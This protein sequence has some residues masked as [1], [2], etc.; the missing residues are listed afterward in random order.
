MT[1]PAIFDHR[2]IPLHTRMSV[3]GTGLR[4][5]GFSPRLVGQPTSLRQIR[6][7]WCFLSGFCHVVII[8]WFRALPWLMS[9]GLLALPLGSALALCLRIAATSSLWQLW[10]HARAALVL[11]PKQHSSVGLTNFI[12]LQNNPRQNAYQCESFVL[13]LLCSSWKL[14]QLPGCFT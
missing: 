9:L 1:R 11:L 8:T 7:K 14:K 6:L 3:C 13:S 12:R 4:F 10:D 5:W 2:G